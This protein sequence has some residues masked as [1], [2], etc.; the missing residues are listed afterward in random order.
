MTRDSALQAARDIFS[1]H[2]VEAQAGIWR[3][4]G[5]ISMSVVQ[6]KVVPKVPTETMEEIGVVTP[7]DPWKGSTHRLVVEHKGKK[8]CVG[9]GF[10]WDQAVQEMRERVFDWRHRGER[11]AR[12]EAERIKKAQSN[13]EAKWIDHL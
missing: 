13:P 11:A 2:R 4:D 5:T 9:S 7:V 3:P 10:S 1:G 8:F 6:G 12:A